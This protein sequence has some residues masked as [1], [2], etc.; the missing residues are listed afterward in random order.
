[1]TEKIGIPHIPADKP[2]GGGK[3]EESPKKQSIWDKRR[4]GDAIAM[5]LTRKGQRILRQER[6]AAQRE[7]EAKE[8]LSEPEKLRRRLKDFD[9]ELYYVP[10]PN[11]PAPED[12]A[13]AVLIKL[14]YKKARRLKLP[15]SGEEKVAAEKALADEARRYLFTGL[16]PRGEEL[17]DSLTD[18]E[19]QKKSRGDLQHMREIND[20]TIRRHVRKYLEWRWAERDWRT[21]WDAWQKSQ[22][23][24]KE[25]SSTRPPD[26]F[27]KWEDAM[28]QWLSVRN[29]HVRQKVLTKEPPRPPAPPEQLFVIS[30]AKRL[31]ENHTEWKVEPIKPD[32][33]M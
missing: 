30:I 20:R 21:R 31:N 25:I 18:A 9:E 1:M 6:S 7:K 5:R 14:L 29:E 3:K 23:E 17:I 16:M 15:K 22:K 24:K 33:A 32:N 28:K 19:K 10:T 8:H 26:S 12:K 13:V 2:G 27:P 4:L 11:K